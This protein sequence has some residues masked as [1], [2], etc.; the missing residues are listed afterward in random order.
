MCRRP[1]EYVQCS[2]H[3]HH[4]RCCPRVWGGAEARTP[5]CRDMQKVIS[6]CC[7]RH[8]PLPIGCSG[9][10]SLIKK[11]VLTQGSVDLASIS[12][13]R[14]KTSR[15]AVTLRP[16]GA[17]LIVRN[18]TPGSLLLS[19]SRTIPYIRHSF[20]HGD[21]MV[22]VRRSACETFLLQAHPRDWFVCVRRKT[23]PLWRPR[24]GVGP[25]GVGCRVCGRRRPG[26]RRGRRRGLRSAGGTACG[27]HRC[28]VGG[29]GFTREGTGGDGLYV[30]ASVG[31]VAR[32]R[33]WV[34]EQ[35]I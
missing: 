26:G 11:V 29:R 35:S 13:S 5:W 23:P 31:A 33:N 21:R 18:T 2:C 8:R 9:A 27:G 20:K 17:C 3:E 12:H 6:L 15:F 7:A 32:P 10:Y 28:H 25:H 1:H 19:V 14:R 16:R 22:A 4:L 34:A 30:H 24:P